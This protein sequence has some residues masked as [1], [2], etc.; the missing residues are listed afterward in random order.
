MHT[1]EPYYRFRELY[2]AEEDERSAFYGKEYSE[3][4]FYSLLQL[5]HR[6]N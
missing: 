1:I 6:S 3:F 4:L 5:K 2:L